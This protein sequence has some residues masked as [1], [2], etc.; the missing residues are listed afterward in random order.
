MCGLCGIVNF[1]NGEPVDPA[2]LR[3]MT[4]TMRRRGPDDEGFYVNGP[5]GLGHRRL[6]IIDLSTGRQPIHNEDGT[7]W[8]VFNGEIY[9]SPDLRTRLER[10]GHRFYT[11]TDTETIVHAYEEYGPD[12]IGLLNGIFAFALWDSLRSRLLLARDRVGIKPLYY[13]EVEGSLV[14][15]SELKSLLQ[16]PNVGK[17]LD[18]VALNQ[19]LSFEYVPTPRSIFADVRKLPPGS[20]L[21]LEAGAVSVSRYWDMSLELSEAGP[22]KSER[23]YLAELKTT[24][25]DVV[26]KELISDVPV[27][28]LLSGGIDSSLIA[29]LMAELN[30]GSVESFSIAFDDPSFDES[31]YAGMVAKHVGTKHH[32]ATLTSKVMLDLVPTIADFLD[33]P[34]GDSSIVPTYLLSRFAAQHVKVVLGGD[35]GDELFAG[36]S[37]LQAHRLTEYYRRLVP[38]LIRRRVVP[39]LVEKLPVSFDNIS[40]DFKARRFV[41]GEGVHPALRHHM[42]LGSFSEAQKRLLLGSL[43]NEG[44]GTV[45]EVIHEHVRSCP[46]KEPLNQILYCDKKLYME[47]DILPKVDRASMANSLEVRVPL[48]NNDMLEFASRLPIEYKLRGFTTKYLLRKAGTGLL[49]PAI[50]HRGKKGFN[51]PVAKWLTGPLRPLAEEMFAEDRLRSQGLFDYPYVNSLFQEHLN[52]RRDNRKLLWTLLIFQIWYDRW[53]K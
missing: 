47:G 48:L 32:E 4:D 1:R 35:G 30:P 27:G 22:P 24:L 36:Y 16:H 25:R 14:F 3:R 18:L 21:S 44:T 45:E 10:A 29:A 6:S 50:L 12:A 17:R 51:M 2:L 5:V 46:A 26:R 43:S 13:A 11:Q 53:A 52:R 20:G 9:N 28:V 23:S 19:Y 7:I 31:S 42:W 39:W 37:T 49:P 41:Q 8:I 34:L 33:E 38:G 40:L 15:G